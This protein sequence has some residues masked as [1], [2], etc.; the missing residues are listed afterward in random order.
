MANDI[1]INAGVALDGFVD[2]YT[3]KL[4]SWIPGYYRSED[5]K[6]P[7][8]GTLRRLIEQ[9]G[10]DAATLRRRI[11][12]LWENN[13]VELA[14]DD[15]LVELGK[16]LATRM[17][18]ALNRRGRRIDVARTIYY[19]RRKG[20]PRV[21]ESLLGDVTGW[22]GATLETARLLARSHHRVRPPD[23]ILPAPQTCGAPPSAQLTARPSR[24][25][26]SARASPRAP[27]APAW[28]AHPRDTRRHSPPPFG[29]SPRSYRRSLL[30]GLPHPIP[31]TDNSSSSAPCG[32]GVVRRPRCPAG[33]QGHR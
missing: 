14:D 30:G 4:W 25:P 9:M 10:G 11:D 22:S 5:A 19:R 29:S 21:I 24:P 31:Q 23:R 18:H 6:T 28:A 8:P 17:V 2:Y 32:C 7:T 3:E 20:T 1:D 33:S 27:S 15:A 12:R 13:F 26:A 16:L